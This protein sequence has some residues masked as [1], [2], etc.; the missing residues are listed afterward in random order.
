MAGWRGAAGVATAAAITPADGTNLPVPTKAIYV[1]GA[2][3][4]KVD[5]QGSCANPNVSNGDGGTVTFKAVPVGT[6]LP[7]RVT[8]VYAAGTTATLLLALA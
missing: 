7:I 1:G 3:D 8:R 6:V 2:G 4:I 5:M